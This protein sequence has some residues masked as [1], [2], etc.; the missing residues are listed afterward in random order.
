[1]FRNALKATVKTVD[2]WTKACEDGLQTSTPSL[3]VARS[4]VG[5]TR[6]QYQILQAQLEKIRKLLSVLSRGVSFLGSRWQKSSKSASTSVNS[7]SSKKSSNKS[8]DSRSIGSKH[9][10]KR[11]R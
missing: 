11:R 7:K 10:V 2:S 1:M 4:G 8:S 5:L 3:E 6:K 9:N